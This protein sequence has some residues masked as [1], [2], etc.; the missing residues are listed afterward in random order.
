[1]KRQTRATHLVN[2]GDGCS[3]IQTV[4]ESERVF[5]LVEGN[6]QVITLLSLLLAVAIEIAEPQQGHTVTLLSETDEI[7][8]MTIENVVLTVTQLLV[9]E[10]EKTG[11]KMHTTTLFL[12]PEREMMKETDDQEVL[13]IIPFL[14]VAKIEKTITE[15]LASI[16]I[17]H[18]EVAGREKMTENLETPIITLCSEA[19]ET[20]SESQIERA[21]NV[22]HTIIQLLAVAQLVTETV[23]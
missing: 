14:V 1:M 18:L 8:K 23:I 19:R 11:G 20:V 7:E 16:Q 6:E 21:V 10:T 13:R 9:A 17:R 12:V 15:C 5:S 4:T 2:K 22:G 3:E